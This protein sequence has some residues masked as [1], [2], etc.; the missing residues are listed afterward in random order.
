M[1]GGA[2]ETWYA[3]A[4]VIRMVYRLTINRFRNQKTLQLMIEYAEA[5]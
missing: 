1:F 5:V 3:D 2:D 4:N